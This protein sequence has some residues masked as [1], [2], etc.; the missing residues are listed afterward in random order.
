M[1]LENVMTK[2][3]FLG[4]TKSG[5]TGIYTFTETAIVLRA[6]LSLVEPG[7]DARVAEPVSAA[8]LVGVSLAQQADGALKLPVQVVHKVLVVST[9]V[10]VLGAGLVVVVATSV[11]LRGGFRHFVFFLPNAMSVNRIDWTGIIRTITGFSNIHWSQKNKVGIT[12]SKI[13]YF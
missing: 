8:G 11:S 2:E 13:T 7:Q 4:W 1:F 5:R 3:I 6:R 12:I 9:L 10:V